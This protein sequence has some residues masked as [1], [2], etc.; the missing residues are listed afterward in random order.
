MAVDISSKLLEAIIRGEEP[1][2]PHDF[3]PVHKVDSY[4]LAFCGWSDEIVERV[5]PSDKTESEVDDADK[6]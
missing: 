1:L 6:D 2:S 3:D 4:I 5:L